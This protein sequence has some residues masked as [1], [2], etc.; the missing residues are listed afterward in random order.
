MDV[1]LLLQ[2]IVT[3]DLLGYISPQLPTLIAVTCFHGL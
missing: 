2:A 1:G 3:E